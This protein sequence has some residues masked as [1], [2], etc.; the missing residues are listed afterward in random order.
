MGLG[1]PD[2]RLQLVERA[3]RRLALAL[4]HEERL[5]LEDED[6][7]PRR[8]HRQRAHRVSEL[9][10]AVGQLVAGGHVAGVQTLDVERPQPFVHDLAEFRGQRRLLHVVFALEEIDRPDRAG[11]DLL[12]HNGDGCDRHTCISD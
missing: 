7:S 9:G 6:D 10:H 4:R 2:E 3:R 8:H 12:S 1:I 11:G 5:G